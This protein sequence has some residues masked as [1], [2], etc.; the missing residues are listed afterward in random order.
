M[1]N[2]IQLDSLEQK[3]E[4]RSSD[5]KSRFKTHICAK[6]KMFMLSLS[7]P[8]AIQPPPNVCTIGYTNNGSLGSQLENHKVPQS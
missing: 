6:R 3:Y 5:S 7:Q 1:S 8:I 2:I 4:C